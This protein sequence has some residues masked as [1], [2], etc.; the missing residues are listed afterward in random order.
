MRN[1]TYPWNAIVAEGVGTFLFLMVGIGASYAADAAFPGGPLGNLVTVALAH[2]LGLLIAVSVFAAIS[3]GHMNPAVTW[4]L[5]LA[6]KIESRRALAYVIAQLI[7]AVAAASLVR[8][9]TPA[10]IPASAVVPSLG[11]GTDPSQGIVIEAALTML[12]LAAVFGTAVDPRAPR[13][14]GIAIGL[15]VAAGI[16]FGGP[17]TGGAM[18]P[19]RWFGPAIVAGDVSNVVIYT[20]GPLVGASVIAIIYR[21]LFLPEANAQTGEMV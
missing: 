19:A 16:M 14:G 2:G 5:W 9:V 7:A 18:N 15:A 10:A 8:Y 12:L 6:G 1:G 4:G 17:L 20:L 21:Y 3:G 13:I 11:G